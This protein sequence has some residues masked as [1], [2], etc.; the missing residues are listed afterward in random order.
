MHEIHEILKEFENDEITLMF[1]LNE[2]LK[3]EYF[4]I[5]DLTSM[6]RHDIWLLEF[7]TEPKRECLCVPSAHILLV[8]LQSLL[9]ILGPLHLNESL[10]WGLAPVI[11]AEVDPIRASDWSINTLK[12]LW[13]VNS[14]LSPDDVAISEELAE[15]HGGG[16]PGQPSYLYPGIVMGCPNYL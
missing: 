4:D 9:H 12:C 13:L 3:K 11:G 1:K 7:L 16:L 15:I 6:F 2:R 10:A 14:R 5:C 8:F